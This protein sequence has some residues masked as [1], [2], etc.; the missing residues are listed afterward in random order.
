M[1]LKY[2]IK[3]EIAT[4]KSDSSMELQINFISWN[5]REPK[6][7]IRKWS[8]DREK[9]S[10]GATLSKEELI[11]LLEQADVILAKLRGEDEEDKQQE[12]NSG[13][14]VASVGGPSIGGQMVKAMI[15]RQEK[16]CEAQD[17]YVEDDD[18]PFKM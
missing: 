10:K 8:D 9:M 18:L 17:T 16:E 3:E 7:D 5:G 1:G 11:G 12:E 13:P 6:Y 15:E 4:V 14:Q 2:E